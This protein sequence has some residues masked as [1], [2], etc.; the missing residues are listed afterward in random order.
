VRLCGR[1][2]RCLMVDISAIRT[3]RAPS[4]RRTY[5]V[6]SSTVETSFSVYTCVNTSCYE[7]NWNDKCSQSLHRLQQLTEL[8]SAIS[9]TRLPDLPD[10]L[11]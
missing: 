1:K 3:S 5:G 11:Q 9:D 8:H 2:Y 4:T 7:M 10:A 6:C